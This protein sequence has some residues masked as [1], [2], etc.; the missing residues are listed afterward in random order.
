MPP[1]DRR[2]YLKYT[3]SATLAPLVAARKSAGNRGPESEKPEKDKRDDSSKER[4]PAPTNLQVE[5]AENPLG[6]EVEQPRLSW[7]FKFFA[8]WCRAV[9]VP[10]TR[11]FKGTKSQAW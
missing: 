4:P 5:Y 10:D 3:G 6:V 11:S 7:Q 8:P 2:E 9:C 1:A